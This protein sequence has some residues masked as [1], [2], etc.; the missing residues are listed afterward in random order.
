MVN[1]YVVK[2]LVT[3]LSGIKLLSF[4]EELMNFCVS[5]SQRH[6]VCNILQISL[7]LLKTGFGKSVE[8]YRRIEIKMKQNKKVVWFSIF[9]A[10]DKGR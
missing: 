7:T 1:K 4:P 8:R 3:F 2:V 9:S 6:L 10:D 5:F